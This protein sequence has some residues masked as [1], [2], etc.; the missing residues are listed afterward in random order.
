MTLIAKSTEDLQGLWRAE[1]ST[2]LGAGCL[3]S[4]SVGCRR[5]PRGCLDVSLI[6][7]TPGIMQCLFES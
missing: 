2:E 4:G 6:L 3:V 1:A 7:S 5:G